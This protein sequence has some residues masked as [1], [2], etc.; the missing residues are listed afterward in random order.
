MWNGGGD[1]Q[2]IF[3]F[4]NN[5]N[6]GTGLTYAM[7]TPRSYQGVLRFAINSGSG[8]SATVWTNAL[9]IGQPTHIALTYDF[10]AGLATLYV[11]G[12]PVGTG[13]ATIPLNAIND[14][15]VWLGRSN[16]QDPY[17]NGTL[18]EFRIYGGVLNAAAVAASYAA[19]PDALVGARPVLRV[20]QSAGALQLSWSADTV[21]Y[22]LEQ[23][24]NLQTGAFWTTVTNSPGTQN[25]QQT[26]TLP[27][28]GQRQFFRLRK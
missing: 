2:R 19:G 13:P 22:R 9:A 21:G 16:W 3:D 7:L 6:Q 23:T 27:F 4:G 1:W 25:Y 12:Q 5:D 8:E 26:V 17:L 14:L 20:I 15:N 24:T 28:S 11:N 10:A 18:Y